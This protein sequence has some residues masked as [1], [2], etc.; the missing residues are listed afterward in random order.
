MGGCNT[1]PQVVLVRPD[2][3]LDPTQNPP[4]LAGH[5]LWCYIGLAGRIFKAS[6][7]RRLASLHLS[8]IEWHCSE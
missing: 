4:P 3:L 5:L 8:V 2:D 6:F 7:R 1:M